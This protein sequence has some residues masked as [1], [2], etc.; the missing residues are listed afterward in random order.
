MAFRNHDPDA[1]LVSRVDSRSPLSSHS[2]QR[3]RLN[4]AD[5][6]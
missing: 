5:W 6:P 1:V 3:I 2:P 4:D